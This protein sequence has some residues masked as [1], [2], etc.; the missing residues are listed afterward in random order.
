LHSGADLKDGDTR[1]FAEFPAGGALLPA[2][3]AA[4]A[5]QQDGEERRSSE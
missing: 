1:I 4:R 3:A 5:Q 2:C